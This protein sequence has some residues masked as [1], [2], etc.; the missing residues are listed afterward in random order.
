M[1]NPTSPCNQTSHAGFA[2]LGVPLLGGPNNKDWNILASILGSPY[3]E[4]LPNR[5][6]LDMPA[7]T[8]RRSVLG[9]M[10]DS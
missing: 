4:N 5:T 9:I 2:K 3:L 10:L 8:P 7:I 1:S 6:F